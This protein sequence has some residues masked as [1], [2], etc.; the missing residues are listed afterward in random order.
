MS[1]SSPALPEEG[2]LA[3]NIVH[4]TRALRTAGVK[5]GTGQVEE[6]IRAVK[7]VGFTKREDFYHT[8]RAVLINRPE[9]LVLYDQVFAMFWRDPDFVSRMMHTLSPVMRSEEEP[10]KKK[11]AERRATEALTDEVELLRDQPPREQIEID[12][13]LSW[14]ANETLK[15]MDFE[16]MS[17]AETAAAT[18]LIKTIKLPL[19]PL[20]SRRSRRASHGLHVDSHSTLRAA[21]RRGGEVEQIIRTQPRLRPPDL[22]VL[23]D[24]SGSMAAYARMMM[25]FLHAL[26][27]TAKGTP[28]RQWGDVYAFTFGTR[29]TNI[30]RSLA[31]RDVDAALDAVSQDA[32][33]WQ[34][35]TRIGDALETFNAKWSRRVLSRGAV[36]LLI[37]DGLERGDLDGLRQQAERL[38][39]SCKRL[40]WLNPLLR[41]DEFSPK[42]GGIKT[43]MPFVDGLYA[44]HSLTSLEQLA[45][46][47]SGRTQRQAA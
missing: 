25:H 18:R 12:A 39:L 26:T 46:V 28:Q 1:G 5:V 15:D 22:A 6:A 13:K 47:F 2:R 44:C 17:T 4:F 41:F 19:P 23:C 3:D 31:K 10:A 30:S 20:A 35:G 33:D 32:Q 21:F 36:V 14:S 42:A 37:T 9:H 27:W 40:V 16:Q 45:D 8:L 43:L 29:L 38:S 11:D 34:G 24:I 7:A